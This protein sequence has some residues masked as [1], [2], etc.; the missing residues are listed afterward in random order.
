MADESKQSAP[1]D[2]SENTTPP[3]PGLV[4]LD[5]PLPVLDTD[6]APDAVEQALLGLAKRGKLAGYHQ[7]ISGGLF[8]VDAFGQPFDH[9]LIARAESAKGRT[10]LVFSLRRRVKMPIVV[11]V[12][13]VVS[14]EPGR[15]FVDQLIPGSWNWISTMWWYYPLTI[16]PIPWIW[17]SMSRKSIA[18]AHDH[19]HEQIGKI[20]QA[21][22]AS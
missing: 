7:K 17:R 2:A 5:L 14:V 10:R 1:T 12:L 4:P 16:L 22:G 13:L 18:A 6:L 3:T 11:A 20:A 8:R 9:D 21:I 19:A 15:Y